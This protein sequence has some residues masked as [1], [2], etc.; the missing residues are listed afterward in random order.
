MKQSLLYILVL[1]IVT[2]CQEFLDAK[3]EKSLIIPN[4]LNDFQALL[5]AEPRFMNSITKMGFLASDEIVLSDALVGLVMLDDRSAYLWE[6]DFYEPD[7]A[8]TDWSVGYQ[9]IFYANVVIEGVRDYKPVNSQE[10]QRARELDAAARFH[11]AFGHFLIAGQFMGPY[12]PANPS[13]PG[14]PI[15]KS[16]DLNAPSPRVSMLEVMELIREDL[17]VARLVLPEFPEIPTRASAW[18]AEALLSRVSLYM[19]D[20]E[21][22]LFHSGNAL[23][24]KDELFDYNDINPALRFIFPRFNVEVIHHAHIITGR[25]QNSNQTYVNP[26]LANLYDVTDLRFKKIIVPSPVAGL[27]N[28]QGRYSGEA[29]LFGGL[30]TD[31]V[32]L[33]YAEAAA[34]TGNEELAIE[35]LNHLLIK[36]YEKNK[37]SPIIGLTGM[38][39]IKK[40]ADERR[41]ELLFRGIRWLDQKRYN[42]DPLMAKTNKR[43]WMG[44]EFRLE[45]GSAKYIFPIPPREIRLNDLL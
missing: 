26:E 19:Q 15:R 30:A 10:Q 40:I 38:A 17:E 1:F 5:D 8:G 6:G 29:A 9:R 39:L 4:T 32:L 42:Q 12:D 27:Y 14:I 20:Y 23:S 13:A 41:K 43:T 34:R 24:I 22:A 36:R 16:A 25:Y 35:K 21:R 44:T 33:D 7:A 31:E 28:F 11:R 45:P 37:F 2:G 3:P 18:G